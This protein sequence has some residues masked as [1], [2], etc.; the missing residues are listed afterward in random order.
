[1]GTLGT[2]LQGTETKKTY[3]YKNVN[4]WLCWLCVSVLVVRRL[5]RRG[6]LGAFECGKRVQRVQVV[7]GVVC[8]LPDGLMAGISNFWISMAVFRFQTDQ[9]GR[10]NYVLKKMDS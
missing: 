2:F 4:C 6:C 3:I 1:M 10:Y 8:E 5:T 9:Y 7:C